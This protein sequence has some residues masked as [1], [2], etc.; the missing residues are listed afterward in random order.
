MSCNYRLLDQS[1]V[2]LAPFDL[3]SLTRPFRVH[4]ILGTELLL[5]VL[6][7]PLYCSYIWA[8]C[9]LWLNQISHTLIRL[10]NQELLRLLHRIY[11]ITQHCPCE[12][13]AEVLL[14]K[15]P[16]A[17]NKVKAR[18]DLMRHEVVQTFAK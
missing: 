13:A 3:K 17:L 11:H 5:S 2:S 10:L 1:T 18:F 7:T 9:L 8:F 4:Q 16:R 15:V 12:G 14:S 6:V